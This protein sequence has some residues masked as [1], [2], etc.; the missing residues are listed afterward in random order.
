MAEALTVHEAFVGIALCAAYA[1]G[2]MGAEENEALTEDLQGCRA[3]QGL[4]EP[5]LRAA[6]MKVDRILSKEGEATLLA[7]AAAALTPEL[8]ATAFCL[9]ADLVLADDELAPEERAFIERLRKGLGLDAAAAQRI[10]DVLLIRA[11]A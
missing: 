1:D 8:R 9:G 4:D 7:R 3:L 2:T 6:M 10:V 5:E 11:R